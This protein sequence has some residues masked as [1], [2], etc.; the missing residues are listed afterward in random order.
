MAKSRARLSKL[1]SWEVVVGSEDHGSCMHTCLHALGLIYMLGPDT[2]AVDKD[3]ERWFVTYW[4]IHLEMATTTEL[5][6]R[7]TGGWAADVNLLWLNLVSWHCVLRPL[8]LMQACAMAH[9]VSGRA[10][11]RAC[12]NSLWQNKLLSLIHI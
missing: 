7:E 2:N 9:I 4:Q 3:E 1:E 10:S 5:R 11:Q 6:V 12:P 8:Q